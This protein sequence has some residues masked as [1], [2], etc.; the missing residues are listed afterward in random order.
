MEKLPWT[1]AV[2]EDDPSMLKSVQRLL[3]VHG[4]F[5]QANAPRLMLFPLGQY[6]TSFFSHIIQ[7]RCTG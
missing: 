5:A 6:T 1:I 4:Y 2:V 7:S 3:N